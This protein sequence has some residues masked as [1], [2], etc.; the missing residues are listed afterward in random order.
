[1]EVTEF[2]KKLKQHCKWHSKGNGEN[3][4]QCCY[5]EF[6]FT[7]PISLSDK[8]VRQTVDHLAQS[9]SGEDL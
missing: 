2:F 5:K 8:I 1:M 3:C 7:P 4:R 9:Q 6:C